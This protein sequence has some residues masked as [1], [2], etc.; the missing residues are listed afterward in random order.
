LAKLKILPSVFAMT[1][2]KLEGFAECYSVLALGKDAITVFSPSTDLFFAEGRFGTRQSLCR[3]RDKKLLAKSSLPSETLPCELCHGWHSA[4]PLPS[5]SRAFA[6][7]GSDYNYHISGIQLIN[8]V[9]TR[10]SEIQFSFK[11]NIW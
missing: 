6:E 3:V 2:G 4:K 9:N 5:V 8:I 10:S 7:P 11:K 1:L